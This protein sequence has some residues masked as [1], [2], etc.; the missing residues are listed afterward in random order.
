MINELKEPGS[1]ETNCQANPAPWKEIVAKYTEP[2]LG[3]ALWQIV[4]TLVPY[5][6]LWYLM[7]LSLSVSYWLT[8]PLAA[9]AGAFLVRVFIIFHDCGH[10]SF[11]KSRAANDFVGFLSGI[12]TFT[13]YYHW[14]WE[15]ALHHASSGDLDR[16]GTGDV[17]TL[18]VE[19]Y[20]E[21]SRWRKFSDRLGREPDGVFRDSPSFFFFWG[22]GVC[23]PD[24]GHRG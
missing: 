4:N 3:R 7:Y 8:I 22:A 5:G 16:R 15:H 19:E 11:F 10:G 9:L 1:I 20:L 21:S 17:W 6:L 14:R 23:N 12:L 13:P 2:S 18:T 24:A